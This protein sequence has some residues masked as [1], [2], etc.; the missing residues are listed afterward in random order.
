[1]TMAEARSYCLKLEHD[2]E[3]SWRE[4]AQGKFEAS[5][6]SLDA[7]RDSFEDPDSVDTF[8]DGG[9]A[10]ESIRSFEEPDAHAVYEQRR[11]SALNKLRNRPQLQRTL[12]LIITN[13]NNRKESVWT[14]MTTSKKRPDGRRRLPA[15]ELT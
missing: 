11:K 4:S 12:R 5:M 9:D 3:R 1:M 8:S 7:L 2:R 15:T 6:H 10:A 13:G 14:L